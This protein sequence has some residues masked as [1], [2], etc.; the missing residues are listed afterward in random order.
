MSNAARQAL[1]LAGTWSF[2][3]RPMAQAL[4]CPYGLARANPPGVGETDSDPKTCRQ[5][6]SLA[7]GAYSCDG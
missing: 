2:P 5:R 4:L 6:R 3:P 1:E 7:A